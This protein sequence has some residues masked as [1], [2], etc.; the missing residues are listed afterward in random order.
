[1][2]TLCCGTMGSIE[3]LREAGKHK[4]KT[5]KSTLMMILEIHRRSRNAGDYLWASG[6][7]NFNLSLFNGISGIGYTILRELN[8]SLPNILIFK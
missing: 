1:M 8:P 4:F 3:L 7:E 6:D 5:G 2:D